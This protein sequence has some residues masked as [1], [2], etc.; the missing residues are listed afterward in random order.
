MI[1]CDFYVVRVC[2]QEKRQDVPTQIKIPANT[3]ENL[4]VMEPGPI[5][6]V[7]DWNTS[8]RGL[9]QIQVLTPF[10]NGFNL[11]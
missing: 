10:S 5:Y 9:G 2:E 6:A 3:Y 11:F 1:Q 8:Y 7:F 4:E